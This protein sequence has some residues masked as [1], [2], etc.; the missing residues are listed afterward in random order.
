M[1]TFLIITLSLFIILISSYVN[2]F[3]PFNHN[4]N[5]IENLY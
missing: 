3:E 2:Y 4:N 1:N 5:V